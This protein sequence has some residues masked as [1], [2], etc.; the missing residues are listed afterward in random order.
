MGSTEFFQPGCTVGLTITHS[1]RTFLNYN[2]SNSMTCKQFDLFGRS[3]V[4]V[5]LSFVPRLSRKSEPVY[6]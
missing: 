5:S 6:V 1:S 4:L 2:T 3:A